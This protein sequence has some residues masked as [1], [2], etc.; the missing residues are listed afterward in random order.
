MTTAI[1]TATTLVCPYATTK[2][3]PGGGVTSC[4]ETTTTYLP[5]PGTYTIAP[6]TVTV[7]VTKS[8]VVVPVL[9][10][11]S[12]G[13]YTAAATTVTVTEAS[14]AFVCPFTTPTPTPTTTL[15]DFFLCP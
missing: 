7:T 6:H 4:V 3:A 10:T 11:Y 9:A 1:E 14:S 2:S 12:P 15:F 13:T 8:V 5:S